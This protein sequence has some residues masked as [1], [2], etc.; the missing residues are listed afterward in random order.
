MAVPTTVLATSASADPRGVP[1]GSAMLIANMGRAKPVCA[2]T[3]APMQVCI[4][5]GNYAGVR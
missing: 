2:H 1:E 5:V 4:H 3:R